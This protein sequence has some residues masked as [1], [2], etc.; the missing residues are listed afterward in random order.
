[1]N[2]P[3]V[4]IKRV[5]YGDPILTLKDGAKSFNAADL[6]AIL[7]TVGTEGATVKEIKNI[8]QDTWGYEESDPTVTEYI[9]QLTGMV[10]YRD[11]EQAGVPT[12][13]FTLGQYELADK[14]ALQGGKVIDGVW[15][16]TDMVNV[17]AK[18]IIAQTKTGNWIVMPNANIVGKG[19]FVNKNIGLGVTAIPVETNVDGLS[20]E[21]WFSDEDVNN[22]AANVTE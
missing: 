22:A 18:L 6:K 10:Y 3:Y 20:A 1:M 8:H 13:S 21:M 4:G 15:H 11:M 12:V 2:K 16:R 7:A 19:A 9:N 5:L 14:A 17:I